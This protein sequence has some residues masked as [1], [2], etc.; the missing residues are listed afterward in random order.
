MK[1][2]RQRRENER[3][4]FRRINGRL[5]PIA[6]GAAGAGA[7]AVVADAAR[8]KRVYETKKF[9]IDR[10]GFSIQPFSGMKLGDGLVMRTRRGARVGQARFY[11]DPGDG[12]ATFSWL[13]VKR[14]FR[15]RGMSQVLS[16]Q[17]AIEM[18]AQ[19]AKSIFNHVVHP[20]SLLTHF[21]G[22]RDK[23]WKEGRAL[24]SGGAMMEQVTKQQAVKSVTRW[25]KETEALDKMGWAEYFFETQ[26]NK[27]KKGG[28]RAI[29][30]ETSL[31]AVP[32]RRPLTPYRTLGNKLRL[33][34][35][36][37]LAAGAVAY[38]ATI[39][40]NRP[41]EPGTTSI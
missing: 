25:R 30:R 14:R 24:K 4:T 21:D 9:T 41:K 36:S 17:A 1:Q 13:G 10:K 33:G 18:K 23:L 3:V 28:A 34:V 15:G 2:Q 19:G 8:T 31:G 16:R 29:F 37:V 40:S 27:G 26:K 32:T 35:G 7:A 6:V 5:V 39:G 20:G 38:L 12:T 22:R 11:V